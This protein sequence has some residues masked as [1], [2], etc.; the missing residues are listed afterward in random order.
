MTLRRR[1]NSILMAFARHIAINCSQRCKRRWPTVYLPLSQVVPPRT[2]LPLLSHPFPLDAV[3]NPVTLSLHIPTHTACGLMEGHD[4]RH[5]CEKG[6]RPMSDSA[7]LPKSVKHTCI[8]ELE[9]KRT[10]FTGE[11]VCTV[12]G[13]YLS[14]QQD[15]PPG[16]RQGRTGT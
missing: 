3:S 15:R 2:P 9:R 11:V 16:T 1:G 5:L 10:V 13:V 12:C 6:G 14:S 8:F 7:Y 4:R